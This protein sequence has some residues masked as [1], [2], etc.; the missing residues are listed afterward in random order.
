MSP[1]WKGKEQFE[2]G[3]GPLTVLHEPRNI[4][5][6]HIAINSI[7][8]SILKEKKTIKIMTDLHQTHPS[9]SDICSYLSNILT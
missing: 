4:K 2:F 1:N 7:T 5:R 3:L 6:V 9:L 8:L